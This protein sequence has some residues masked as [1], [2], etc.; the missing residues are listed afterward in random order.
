VKELWA[1]SFAL[2]ESE[3]E[4]V[5]MQVHTDNTPNVA[6]INRQGTMC[7]ELMQ[8]VVQSLKQNG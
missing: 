3:S 2:Q 6:A 1:V 7:S 4:N 5:L 8:E